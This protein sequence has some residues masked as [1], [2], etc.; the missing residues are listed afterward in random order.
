MHHRAKKWLWWWVKSYMK[1]IVVDIVIP[2]YCFQFTN[3]AT[4]TFQA[5][6]KL[7]TSRA[8]TKVGEA[9][10]LYSLPAL[11]WGAFTSQ[12]WEIITYVYL[13]AVAGPP[14]VNH[15]EIITLYLP[16]SHPRK[17][18]DTSSSQ[19]P[20]TSRSFFSSSLAVMAWTRH[21]NLWNFQCQYS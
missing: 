16:L 15:S 9:I 6:W 20:K 19:Q 10:S 4:I 17:K 3:I 18:G 2:E 21:G 12:R 11:P 5:S 14:R 8:M 7:S 1:S 13:V